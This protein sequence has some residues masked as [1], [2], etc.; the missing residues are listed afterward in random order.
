MMDRVLVVEA[1]ALETIGLAQ[2]APALPVDKYVTAE[3]EDPF[4]QVGMTAAVRD[5]DDQEHGGLLG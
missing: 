2:F 5:W 1:I 3:S 4:H